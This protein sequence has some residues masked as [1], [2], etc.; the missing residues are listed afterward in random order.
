MGEEE[1]KKALKVLA[2]I[3][4]IG[5]VI[6]ASALLTGKLLQL[7]KVTTGLKVK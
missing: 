1:A 5:G 7:L 4:A 6:T 3:G 2:I